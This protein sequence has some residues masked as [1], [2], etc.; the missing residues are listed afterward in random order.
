[1]EDFFNLLLQS[2]LLVWVYMTVLFV[3]ALI[4]KD[5]S[6]A[7]IGWGLGFILVA[8]YTFLQ[9]PV[10]FTTD[11][12]VTILVFLWGVRLSNS[13]FKRNWGKGED[14]RYKKWRKEWGKLFLIRS[15]LQV[16]ILQGFFM[17][18]IIS[19]VIYINS[20]VEQN[21]FL[22]F[23]G[24]GIWIF[25]FLFETIGDK[26]LRVFIQTRKNR[27]DVMDKGL[28]KYTRHPNYFGEAVMWWGIWLISFNVFLLVSPV[29]IT[30][31]LRFV[32][33]VPLLEKKMM[34]NPKFVQYAKRTSP[35]IPWF[36]KSS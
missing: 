12:L 31:L 29:L 6:I 1:M 34:Q 33:G 3:F 14:F 4:K 17:L 2:A 36:P 10:F 16:F 20:G 28:W 22:S 15:Y 8:F 23:L 7:D 24:L 30:V 35:F 21:F 26:Q 25:G 19:P 11:V 5:N 9:P 18:I 27:D 32:S 13:I